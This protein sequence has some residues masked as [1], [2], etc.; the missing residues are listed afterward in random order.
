M[1]NKKTGQLLKI[2]S[3]YNHKDLT[4]IERL[5][6]LLLTLQSVQRLPFT[7]NVRQMLALKFISKEDVEEIKKF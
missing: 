3:L 7:T 1:E 2:F 5:N 4:S 6:Y